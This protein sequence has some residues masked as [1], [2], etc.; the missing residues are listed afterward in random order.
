MKVLKQHEPDR[1]KHRSS[2]I[3]YIE[4]FHLKI[5]LCVLN[6]KVVNESVLVILLRMGTFL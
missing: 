3:S 4:V 1:A 6:S 2:V 5:K